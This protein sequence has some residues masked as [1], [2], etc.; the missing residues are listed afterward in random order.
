MDIVFGILG[1]TA[2]RIDGGLDEDWGTPRLSAMLATLLVHAGR[3]VP[4]DTLVAW[5][6]PEEGDTPQNPASTF[7]TY[8]TRLRKSLQ[9]LAKPP[10]LYVENGCYRLDVDKSLIDYGR[11]R[12]LIG[13]AR[14]H[15]RADA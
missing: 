9:R 12:M 13:Q 1:R 4:I 11:F 5:V 15:A 10:T 6:W 14:A 8:A 2:L 7:H 3:A